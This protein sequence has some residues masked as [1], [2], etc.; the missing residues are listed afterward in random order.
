MKL[1]IRFKNC[2]SGSIIK[3]LTLRRFC[4]RAHV[5]INT[6]WVVSLFM[7]I[8]SLSVYTYLYAQAYIKGLELRT[9]RSNP[10]N[11]NWNL[12]EAGFNRILEG[13]SNTSHTGLNNGL[14]YD[15][16]DVKQSPGQILLSILERGPENGV[17][18]VN[19]E[20]VI[21]ISAKRLDLNNIST[22]LSSRHGVQKLEIYNGGSY[23]NQS[24]LL[25]TTIGQGEDVWYEDRRCRNPHCNIGECATN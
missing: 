13:I 10:S 17:L 9:L 25:F 12:V 11:S 14:V 23:S 2:P 3:K 8:T 7:F 21:E 19:N 5:S 22:L 15:L 18:I 24:K 20:A 16:K 6:L 1:Y 4:C